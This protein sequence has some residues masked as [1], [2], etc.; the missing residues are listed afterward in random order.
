VP[1]SL[2]VLFRDQKWRSEL[3]FL[4]TSVITAWVAPTAALK[5]A[6][7]GV[8]TLAFLAFLVLTRGPARFQPAGLVISA[9]G[10][11]ASILLSH[12]GIGE[13]PALLCAVYSRT[14]FSEQ[15]GKIVTGLLAVAFALTVGWVGRSPAGLLAG[16]GV[17]VL[18]SRRLEQLQLRQ[19]HAR[20]LTLLAEL[21]A[22]RDA[23]TQAAALQE[24]G[25]I[26]REM[27]DV[28]AHSLSGLSLQLQATRAVAQREG[29]GP[30]VMEPLE[31]A[32]DLARNGVEEAKAV[33]G[34]LRGSAGGGT[35]RGLDDLP[36]LV[37]R[38]PGDATL[39]VIG[40]PRPIDVAVGHAVY[41]AV[42][43][44][45]TNAARYAPGSPVRVVMQW[46]PEHLQ[47][48]IDDDG[49]GDRPV[50]RGQGSGEGLRGM[51]E[52][53]A[54][55]GGELSARPWREGWRTEVVVP[56]GPDAWAEGAS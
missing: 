21:E 17:P 20:T 47:A 50:V 33:V 45:L 24:R 8:L 41:R 52:R 43:E 3:T 14:V 6:T 49:P 30:A 11:I 5:G 1:R 36:T 55:I 10:G 16:L 56:L 4:V 25:R 29:I 26:A 53:V 12:A 35:T 46:K 31:R 19:E 15:A 54:A 40:Q 22:A 38:F 51:R 44:S 2:S 27:H 23:Q 42:Q 34:A 13:A 32:A 28:L 7:A 9:A 48:I 18:A 37:E 39:E